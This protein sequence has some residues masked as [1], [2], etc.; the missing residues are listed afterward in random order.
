MNH[1]TNANRQRSRKGRKLRDSP[2]KNENPPLR[3]AGRG[4]YPPR[5]IK[6]PSNFCMRGGLSLEKF[7]LYPPWREDIPHK[8]LELRGP[9]PLRKKVCTI[10]ANRLWYIYFSV[11]TC[12]LTRGML[13]ISFVII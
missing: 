1:D 9:P 3:L 2:P 8:F 12:K 13:I 5:K 4:A 6:S 10:T 7:D 11:I